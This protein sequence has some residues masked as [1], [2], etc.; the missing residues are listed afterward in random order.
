MGT[1][2]RS[3]QSTRR[4][5]KYGYILFK[6]PNDLIRFLDKYLL[7]L[8]YA[9]AVPPELKEE[10]KKRFPEHQF[11]IIANELMSMNRTMPDARYPE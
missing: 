7:K 11:D 5:R 8:G 2:T 6:I 3:N 10:A 1:S 9:V 4:A